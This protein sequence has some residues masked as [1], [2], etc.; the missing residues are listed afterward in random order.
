M[1]KKSL[2][3][4]NFEGGWNNYFEQRDIPDNSATSMIG[5]NCSIVGKLIPL[6]QPVNFNISS[7]N[8]FGQIIYNHAHGGGLYRFS[9]D[10]TIGERRTALGII[11]NDS[12][13]T[14][15]VKLQLDN[16]HGFGVGDVVKIS[17]ITK[18]G[19]YIVDG[20]IDNRT[21]LIVH[22]DIQDNESTALL[23]TVGAVCFNIRK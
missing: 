6:S 19:L 23:N 5:L 10:F 1:P 2:T 3:I 9:S 8:K 22:A 21:I 4:N 12:N 18:D 7:G 14:D 20:I 16:M 13:I 17:G 11:D 15:S